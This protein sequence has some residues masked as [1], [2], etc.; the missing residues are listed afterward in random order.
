MQIVE[1]RDHYK[2]KPITLEEKGFFKFQIKLHAFYRFN[3]I[4]SNSEPGGYFLIFSSRSYMKD[5]NSAKFQLS[6][7]IFKAFS[8]SLSDGYIRM[9]I[10]SG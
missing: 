9:K 2:L 7:S 8:E 4:S 10:K 1:S 6:G 5:Y 3:D